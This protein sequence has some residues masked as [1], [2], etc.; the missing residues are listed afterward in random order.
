MVPVQ[1]VFSLTNARLAIDVQVI[2]VAAGAEEGTTG[3]DTVLTA[4]T[5]TDATLVDVDALARVPIASI[6]F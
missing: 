5:V 2:S 1:T 6:C 3:V 4:A